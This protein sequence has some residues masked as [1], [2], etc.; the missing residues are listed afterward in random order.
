MTKDVVVFATQEKFIEISGQSESTYPK[1]GRWCC[2]S[3]HT[4]GDQEMMI[5]ADHIS[6]IYVS[7][8][9]TQAKWWLN[10]IKQ[11]NW[12][13]PESPKVFIMNT[14]THSR[15]KNVHLCSQL[16]I[17]HWPSS[18]AS[19]SL[20]LSL[21]HR[22][23]KTCLRLQEQRIWKACNIWIF[24]F[25]EQVNNN[26]TF[27][28]LQEQFKNDEGDVSKRRRKEKFQ[29]VPILH[30]DSS[31]ICCCCLL[32]AWVPNFNFAQSIEYAHGTNKT[33][34]TAFENNVSL[35]MEM[36]IGALKIQIMKINE[37][38]LNVCILLLL[39]FVPIPGTSPVFVQPIVLELATSAKKKEEMQVVIQSSSDHI[40]TPQKRYK[41]IHVL[42]ILV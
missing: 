26:A 16:C 2:L 35:P 28:I 41:M 12:W 15:S 32:D 13:A 34:Q 23:R 22:R 10:R 3:K 4:H 18:L 14:H 9:Y 33:K 19:I 6:T 5:P 11:V 30:G 40:N 38:R 29:S 25:L 24:P 37:H 17:I 42:Q 1:M 8:Q 21:A 31:I 27:H 36:W 20:E 7:S 39:R